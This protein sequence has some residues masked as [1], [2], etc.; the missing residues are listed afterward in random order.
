MEGRLRVRLGRALLVA[1]NLL[2]TL[3]FW[4]GERLQGLLAAGM[5]SAGEGH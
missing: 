1:V 4:L 5:T 2:G 3:W